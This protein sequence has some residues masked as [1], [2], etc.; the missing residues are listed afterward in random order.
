MGGEE[1]LRPEYL[2]E[3]VGK[4]GECGTSGVA[5]VRDHH[6]RELPVAHGI[7]SAVRE[8]VK[9]DVLVL[10]KEGVVPGFPYRFRSPL[11]RNQVQLLDYPDL[12]QLKRNAFPHVELYFWHNCPLLHSLGH[13][14][15]AVK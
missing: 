5:V 6:S 2:L 9:E 11:D 7:D 15:S 10:E 8:H 3:L 14:V 12:M 1:V 4:A 13:A